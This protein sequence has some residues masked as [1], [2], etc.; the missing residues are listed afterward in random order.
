MD[1]SWTHLASRLVSGAAPRP[2]ARRRRGK[3]S[4]QQQQRT[5]QLLSG[6]TFVHVPKVLLLD[7]QL[8]AIAVPGGAVN[9]HLQARRPACDAALSYVPTLRCVAAFVARLSRLRDARSDNNVTATCARLL[10]TTA[11]AAHGAA[12]DGTV[13]AG[14]TAAAGNTAAAGG[15]GAV[16][17]VAATPPEGDRDPTVCIARCNPCPWW[18][19]EARCAST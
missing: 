2:A 17:R 15:S 12:T 7:E 18:P 13:A 6:D 10:G 19:T 3:H 5:Q 4:S 1:R 11:A 9:E 16:E 8:A 14:D